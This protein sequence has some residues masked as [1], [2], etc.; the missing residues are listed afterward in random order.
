MDTNDIILAPQQQCLVIHPEFATQAKIARVADARLEEAVRLAAAIELDVRHA[1]IVRIN[2]PSPG[3]LFGRGTV[4]RLGEIIHGHKSSEPHTNHDEHEDEDEEPI[5]RGRKRDHEP[6]PHPEIELAIINAPLS[7]VQQRNLE[8][9]WDCKV[10]DR[11]GLILEIFGARARTK[12]GRL[13]VELAS[14]SYQKSRLVRSWTHLERQ[15]GGLGFVGGPGE[16]QIETDRRLINERIVLIK[17][18]LKSV[19]QTRRLHRQARERV[20]YRSVALVGYTNAGKSTLFN[21]LTQSAVLAKDQLFATLDPTMRQIVLPSGEIAILSDTVG[22]I[23]DLPHELVTAF[24]ATLEEV[25]EADIILHVQDA[26]HD[27]W[28]A[29]RDDVISILR[30]L[31]VLP[32]DGDDQPTQPI[33]Q[34]HIIEVINKTDLLDDDSLSNIENKVARAHDP[35]VSLSAITGR[36]TQ[37]LL[38][39]IDEEL[40]RDHLIADIT[41]GHEFGADAAWLYEHGEVLSR[42]DTADGIHLQVRLSP[43]DH[44]RVQD[45]PN[46]VVEGG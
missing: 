17:R 34:S 37:E 9:A 24:H 22:F 43:T 13:Q 39:R 19:E 46:L 7:P 23:S 35:I 31:G 1:E 4:E 27:D 42:E 14:L 2:A 28:D 40:T 45:N 30:Q 44:S 10:I 25:C 41:M 5:R 21:R 12:A 11:T 33:S 29:Q 26:S 16:T 36:G 20:P 8:K 38:N 32:P 18:Q 6:A 3:K 15:R